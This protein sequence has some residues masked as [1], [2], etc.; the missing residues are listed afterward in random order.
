MTKSQAKKIGFSLAFV[1]L[2]LILSL[3]GVAQ[4]ANGAPL[5]R[6]ITAEII[7]DK[8]GVAVEKDSGLFRNRKKPEPDRTEPYNPDTA[9]QFD[10][11]GDE[12]DSEDTALT[13]IMDN[14]DFDTIMELVVPLL[15]LFGGFQLGTS[16]PSVKT[17]LTVLSKILKK[18]KFREIADSIDKPTDPEPDTDPT[19]PVV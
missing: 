5:D 12:L 8:H 14:L 7:L 15:A 16:D 10:F 3:I 18:G 1:W 6:P 17:I 19:D 9:P 2:A 4:Y 11:P 13:N